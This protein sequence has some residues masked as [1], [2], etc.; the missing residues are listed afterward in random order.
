MLRILQQTAATFIVLSLLIHMGVWIG[1][2]LVPKSTPY[3][4]PEK[5]IEITILPKQELD[6]HKRRQ[7]VEQ[8]EKPLN[9]EVPED[10]KYLSQYNQRVVKETKAQNTGKFTNAAKPGQQSAGQQQKPQQQKPQQKV[11]KSERSGTMP[12]LKDLTPQFMATPKPI[13]E[14]Q[15]VK[16]AGEESQTS[17]HLKDVQAD[18]QTLLNTREFKYATYYHRIRDQIRQYWEPS[19]REKVKKIFAQGRTL[20]STQ[21]RITRVMVILDKNG[22]LVRVKILGQSGVQDFDDAATEAFKA[23]E[24]FPNPPDG[25]IEQDGTIKI[26]WDFV[27]EASINSV[28][29]K[30]VAE[31]RLEP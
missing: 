7:V 26:L 21:D 30:T 5:P 22:A 10:T 19:I 28:N 17:D 20:A 9:D 6:D 14:E 15:E 11:T 13:L 31:A 2:N 18:I 4:P 12:L 29:R 8:S 1:V 24:P 3:K 27:L 25:M 23:A 16:Q